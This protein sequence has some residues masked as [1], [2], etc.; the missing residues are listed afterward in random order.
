MFLDTG[1]HLPGEL[2]IRPEESV[3]KNSTKDKAE[4]VTHQ[5]KGAVKE[6]VGK[7]IADRDLKNEGAAEKAGG[8]AQ[9]KIGDVEEELEK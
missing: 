8:K 2:E 3:M 7:A 5:V 4:G 1:L 6:T 9:K